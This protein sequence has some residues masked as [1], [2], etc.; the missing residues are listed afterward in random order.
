MVWN[1]GWSGFRGER[2]QGWLGPEGWS[3][4]QGKIQEEVRG[5]LL[6][7]QAGWMVRRRCKQADESE[8]TRAEPN[9]VS[10]GSE[11][12]DKAE[13]CWKVLHSGRTRTNLAECGCDPGVFVLR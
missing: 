4:V 7:Y 3:G 9:P 12:G 11:P 1:E 13:N 2:G 5:K 10:T 8:K 6:R